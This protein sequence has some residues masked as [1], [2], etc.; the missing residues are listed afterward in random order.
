[1]LMSL[2]LFLLL[3][4]PS[5]AVLV[6]NSEMPSNVGVNEATDGTT[7][8]YSFTNTA[9]TLLVC[10]VSVA[11]GGAPDITVSGVTYSGAA[12]TKFNE[13]RTVAANS[14]Y[15]YLWFLLS[16]ASGANN[17][18]ITT[19]G[20]PVG[21]GHI[22]SGCISFTG[23]HLTTPLINSTTKTATG[24]P[25]TDSL[26]VTNTISGNI[27]LCSNATGETINSHTQTESWLKNV[28]NQTPANNN[29]LMRAGGGGTVNFSVTTAA[30]DHHTFVAA[31]VQA[32]P[33]GNSMSYYMMMRQ[34]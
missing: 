19:S 31:E 24:T 27:V 21:A 13:Q 30:G 2:L 11:D 12:L 1:M 34:Q 33:S 15:N 3:S 22:I 17:I 28:N 5:Y 23:N 7:F 6:V 4:P 10:S 8:T 9:G 32:P 16:P 14:A 18:V 29:V 20:T 25:T 26:D